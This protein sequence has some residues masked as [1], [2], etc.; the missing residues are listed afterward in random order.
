MEHLQELGLLLADPSYQFH[1]NIGVF[2][3]GSHVLVLTLEAPFDVDEVATVPIDAEEVVFKT[4]TFLC[5][6]FRVVL[7]VFP[8]LGQSVCEFAPLLVGTVTILHEF[9]AK[10]RLFLVS[11]FA[12]GSFLLILGRIGVALF[13]EP[14]LAS[15]QEAVDVVLPSHHD[16]HL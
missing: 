6:V 12:E 7:V 5:F 15:V 14:H 16:G 4:S 11:L 9:F 13:L 10:L 8:Q 2:L 3:P 1:F